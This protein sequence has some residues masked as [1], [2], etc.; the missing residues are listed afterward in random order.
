MDCSREEFPARAEFFVD[1]RTQRGQAAYYYAQGDFDHFPE[2]ECHYCV[3]CEI[4][5]L[6][7]GREVGRGMLYMLRRY[8]LRIR[9]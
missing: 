9:L 3:C 4:Y 1:E 5:L 8:L 7:G 2:E 6:G